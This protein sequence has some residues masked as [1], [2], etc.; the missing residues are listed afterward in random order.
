[1]IPAMVVG[2]TMKDSVEQMFVNP[3]LVSIMLLITG[4]LL[5][6]TRF[7]SHPQKEVSAGRGLL[8]GI[9]Q[10]MAI[11]P[12]ISRSGSTISVGLF[13]GISRERVA[14]FSFL[15]VL[16]VLAGAMFLEMLEVMENG[17]E[18]AA[19]V[20]LTVGFFTSFIAGYIALSYLIILLKREQFHYFSWY[21]WTVGIAGII[22][23]W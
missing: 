16:P 17:I 3:F 21:C 8:M 7:V 15:M 11:I 5:F 2:F 12:G 18:N 19:V 1:M 13:C 20:N 9:A 23:F 4:C 14:N 22:Y 6:A 10:A